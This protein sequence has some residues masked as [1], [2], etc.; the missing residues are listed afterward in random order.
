MRDGADIGGVHLDSERLHRLGFDAV[1]VFIDDFGATGFELVALA[2][3][4]FDKD[5]EVEL[6]AA[7][8]FVAEAV[9]D[10]FES[11]VGFQFPLETFGDLAGSRKFA[12]FALERAGVRTDVNA[13]GGRFEFDGGESFGLVA[14]G[15]SVADVGFVDA[16]NGDDVAGGRLQDFFF[17]KTA[18]GKEVFNFGV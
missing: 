10:D 13:E 4:G 6:A 15:D 14:S 17:A 16:G 7:G 1:D 9:G 8:D 2:T 11:D 12:F 5:G 18:I 3:H